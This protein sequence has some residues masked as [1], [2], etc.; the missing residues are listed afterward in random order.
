MHKGKG[1]EEHVENHLVLAGEWDNGRGR[2]RG[3]QTCEGLRQENG[4]REPWAGE[5]LMMTGIWAQVEDSK[6]GATGRGTALT[7]SRK[8]LLVASQKG[9]EVQTS[10]GGQQVGAPSRWMV[11]PRLGELGGGSGRKEI[12]NRRQ[13][14]K[15]G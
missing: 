5:P 14:V 1:T 11:A 8:E 13:R 6:G 10:G 12:S 15:Y 7:G 2:Q 9:R 4:R 3:E